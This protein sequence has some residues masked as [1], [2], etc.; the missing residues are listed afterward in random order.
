LSQIG[1]TSNTEA[2]LLDCRAFYT[3]FVLDLSSI[4]SV[5]STIYHEFTL[6]HTHTHTH[7]HTQNNVLQKLYLDRRTYFP[8]GG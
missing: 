2:F 5:Y 1:Q 4:C 7:T 3:L 8:W 6:C